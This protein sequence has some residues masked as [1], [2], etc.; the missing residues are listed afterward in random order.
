[1]N[2]EQKIINVRFGK[3]IWGLTTCFYQKTRELKKTILYV[4]RSIN[5]I[6]ISTFFETK[7]KSFD[8]NVYI[9]Y[10]YFIHIISLYAI[11]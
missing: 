11:N 8:K 1:M 9:F 2:N 10:V 3:V 5:V 4:I 7:K 6:L